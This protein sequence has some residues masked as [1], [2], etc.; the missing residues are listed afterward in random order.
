MPGESAESLSPKPTAEN[1]EISSPS[2]LPTNTDHERKDTLPQG[3]PHVGNERLIGEDPLKAAMD[4]RANLESGSREASDLSKS[5]PANKRLV[6]G[7]E[8]PRGDPGKIYTGEEA[9]ELGRRE[10]ARQREEVQAEGFQM[11]P[12]PE[13]VTD[14][15]ELSKLAEEAAAKVGFDPANV[16][17]SR[18]AFQKA[19]EEARDYKPEIEE[20]R[21]Y[22]YREM[23][24]EIGLSLKERQEM[25][26]IQIHISAQRIRDLEALPARERYRSRVTLE[27]PTPDGSAREV[28]ELT[29]Y[30]DRFRTLIYEKMAESKIE[31]RAAAY[32]KVMEDLIGHQEGEEIPMDLADT[33]IRYFDEFDPELYTVAT[34][35]TDLLAR[36]RLPRGMDRATLEA[37]RDRIQ[38]EE[39]RTLEQITAEFRQEVP[40][41]FA[42]AKRRNYIQDQELEEVFSEL[43]NGV[44]TNNRERIMIARERMQNLVTKGESIDEL[45]REKGGDEEKLVGVASLYYQRAH[46]HFNNLIRTDGQL[47]LL[48]PED[49]FIEGE[50]NPRDVDYKF[51]EEGE[52]HYDA[53]QGYYY[54]VSARTQQEFRVAAESFMESVRMG[55]YGRDAGSIFT[56]QNQFREALGFQQEVIS[57]KIRP[58]KEQKAAGLTVEDVK[59]AF[60][61]SVEDTKHKLET[62]V[63]LYADTYANNEYNAEASVQAKEALGAGL[64]PKKRWRSLITLNEGQLMAALRLMDFDPR[65]RSIFHPHGSRAEYMG[66]H[67][68]QNILQIVTAK[69]LVKRLMRI[70]LKDYLNGMDPVSEKSQVAFEENLKR[71]G[72]QQNEQDFRDLYEGFQ[73]EFWDAAAY[74]AFVD[75]VKRK[76]DLIR[77]REIISRQSAGA[78]ISE[79]DREFLYGVGDVMT[80]ED[81]AFLADRSRRS[82]ADLARR[83]KLERKRDLI[84]REARGEVW[85]PADLAFIDGVGDSMNPGEQMFL[86][87]MRSQKMKDLMLKKDLID[88]Q[89]AGATLTAEERAY[90][91]EVGHRISDYDSNLLSQPD[92]LSTYEERAL[93]LLEDPEF[94]AREEAKATD[95]IDF[96]METY[97]ASGELAVRA[98]P[99]FLIRRKENGKEITEAIPIP[100]AQK[101]VQFMVTYTK[102]KYGASPAHLRNEMVGN[103][104]NQA[105]RVFFKYGYDAVPFDPNPGVPSNY[106]RGRDPRPDAFNFGAYNPFIPGTFTPIEI[107][108]KRDGSVIREAATF[109]DTLTHPFGMWVSHTYGDTQ[110]EVRHQLLNPAI[111]AAR[112]RILDGVSVA[113]DEDALA[114]LALILDPTKRILRKPY[115]MDQNAENII[116]G[117]AYEG[118]YLDH[119]GINQGLYG[120]AIHLGK[121]FH[122]LRIYYGLQD[123]GGWSKIAMFPQAFIASD[124][125]AN[126]RRGAEFID[127]LPLT[128][129]SLPEQMGARGMTG[130]FG[131]LSKSNEIMLKTMGEDLG[132]FSLARYAKQAKAMIAAL[133][134]LLGDMDWQRAAWKEGLMMKP[135][136]SDYKLFRHFKNLVGQ[137]DHHIGR[138]PENYVAFIDG[139][140][141]SL[142]R[143]KIFNQAVVAF[144][145]YRKAWRFLDLRGIDVWINND[146]E[147][148]VPN[149]AILDDDSTGSSRHILDIWAQRFFA[150]GRSMGPRGAGTKYT[151]TQQYRDALRLVRTDQEMVKGHH[152]LS[153]GERLI[154]DQ[155]GRI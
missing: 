59:K 88:R 8:V 115:N 69:D 53:P 122:D 117:S 111:L 80:A 92:R 75:N 152:G 39:G 125:N 133:T 79:D 63:F 91:D 73:E 32:R 41:Y 114:T 45:L 55:I 151:D 106:R 29:Y 42:E 140:I 137:S 123:Y 1:P 95:V 142:D 139:A 2:L 87:N 11:F 105:L 121:N 110:E 58:T 107:G 16:E 83:R 4:L 118:V 135:Y 31:D 89:V 6:L 108:K 40:G 144:E 71:V 112:D 74:D 147:S 3:L 24:P 143:F 34:R 90:L 9:K 100:E 130:F 132:S 70:Q 84:D 131:L 49:R 129:S 109:D 19:Y 5:S 52:T 102:M 22:D 150:Y 36:A 146:F 134:A 44:R 94:A 78:V 97:T 17:E 12:T 99:N 128:W 77:K 86:I 104:I 119:Y 61:A 43:M 65:I 10:Q 27:G 26:E 47:D 13:V 50:F 62:Q 148:G 51:F 141:E 38:A 81:N 103:A 28:P 33:R 116:I 120:M 30:Y 20:A 7:E 35:R 23:T 126:S 54:K 96:A 124:I 25:R 153:T 101:F 66:D 21:M 57:K 15:N 48:P 67:D 64:E 82:R 37:E 154:L 14:I 145:N 72:N 138:S 76:R 98:A 136:N 18:K 56:K 113:E 155:T 60:N 85:G 149:P 68:L 46:D 127:A 93:R